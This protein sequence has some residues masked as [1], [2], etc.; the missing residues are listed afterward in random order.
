MSYPYTCAKC[1]RWMRLD[2]S[3][4]K[5]SDEQIISLCSAENHIA[6]ISE[7]HVA[8]LDI[9]VEIKEAFVERAKHDEP[10]L[11]TPDRYATLFFSLEANSKTDTLYPRYPVCRECADT[12][13]A[14]M[15]Q[16]L[17]CTYHD[18]DELAL[19]ERE[20]ERL[21]LIKGDMEM[22]SDDMTRW[23]R[24]QN[25]L[26]R[27]MEKMQD[28]CEETRAAL[29]KL[30]E[31][32][33]R[34]LHM[35]EELDVQSQALS[36]EGDT[37]WHAWN[38]Q[39]AEFEQHTSEKE[40]LDAKLAEESQILSTLSD[41]NAYTDAFFIDKDAYGMGTING[42]RLGRFNASR[43]PQDQVT[44]TEVNVA[45]G[46]VALLFNMLSRKLEYESPTYKVKARG[47]QSTVERLA[48]EHAEYELHATSEWHVGRLFHSRRFDCAMEGFLMS[49]Q[50]LYIHAKSTMD[51][52]L[53]LPYPYVELDTY[54][55]ASK[56]V[57]LVDSVSASNL[58]SQPLGRLRLVAS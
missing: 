56:M 11:A 29:H 37:V 42:L 18:R 30:D 52:T 48:P 3:I 38:E 43:P 7:D 24:D 23:N 4:T 26:E 25:R 39:A 5:A 22:S 40:R 2:E 27:D 21:A 33:Q 41:T 20:L 51:P 46:Q 57:S 10:A 54:I 31:E 44:W 13:I 14:T 32:E 19:L 28:V 9:P 17:M 45:W 15:E 1:A 35:L 50:D 36:K 55:A 34:I 49:V 58:I 8:C 47:A 6:P 12:L 53:M 16:E